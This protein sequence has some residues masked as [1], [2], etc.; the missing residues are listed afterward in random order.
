MI[1]GLLS[2]V[3]LISLA[4]CASAS[5]TADG[6]KTKADAEYGVKYTVEERVITLPQ[7]QDKWYLTV[8]GDSDAGRYG[9]VRGWFDS[10][11]HLQ[12][13]KR[14]T[15]FNAITTDSVMYRDRY[16]KHFREAPCVR[17]QSADGKVLFQVSGTNIP[18]TAD[19]LNKAIHAE[20]L[21]RRNRCDPHRNCRPRPAPT[22]TPVPEPTPLDDPQPQPL[23]T[24]PLD[25][26]VDEQP[27]SDL[28]PW[29]LLALLFA[30]GTSAGVV[31]KWR[32]TY[33][34][35]STA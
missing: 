6:K 21:R 10:H 19:A 20:L 27:E 22:P 16:A 28:P 3:L 25:T 26:V 13:L 9:E 33:Y 2:L 35:Q 18:M 32:E 4:T 34:P 14:G 17:L 11:E 7:D 5:V 31:Q 29:W 15:H 8:V 12:K 23:D 30:A 24:A 1:R